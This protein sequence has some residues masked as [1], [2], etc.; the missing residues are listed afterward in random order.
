MNQLKRLSKNFEK[1]P[2]ITIAISKRNQLL[3]QKS[4]ITTTTATI[5]QRKRQKNF[6]SFTLL[7]KLVNNPHNP[8]EWNQTNSKRIQRNTTSNCQIDMKEKLMN[9]P[10]L[11]LSLSICLSLFLPPLIFT[12]KQFQPILTRNPGNVSRFRN[13]SRD[14]RGIYPEDMGKNPNI[15]LPK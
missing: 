6:Y 7:Q 10:R 14:I 12:Y 3:K 2:Q 15:Q 4:K 8:F 13:S 5:T 1:K 11:F 9:Y